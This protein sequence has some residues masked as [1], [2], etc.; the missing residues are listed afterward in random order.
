[1]FL[2]ERLEPM[3][4]EELKEAGEELANLLTELSP[5]GANQHQSAV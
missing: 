1:M 2:L 5:G 4:L 3:S